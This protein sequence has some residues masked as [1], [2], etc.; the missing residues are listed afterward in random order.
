MS[1]RRRRDKLSGKAES[2]AVL[3]GTASAHVGVVLTTP[4]GDEVILQRV[5]GNAF[6]DPVTQSLAGRRVSVEGYRLGSVFRFDKHSDEGPAD[7]PLL[8]PRRRS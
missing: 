5:G 6:Q 3:Q 2:R 1:K 7:P 8:A 4:Q